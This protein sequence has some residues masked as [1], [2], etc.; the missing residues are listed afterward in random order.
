M[1]YMVLPGIYLVGYPKAARDAVNAF[2][3]AGYLQA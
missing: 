3:Y 2:I 1:D